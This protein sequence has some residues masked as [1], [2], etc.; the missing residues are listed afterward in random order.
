MCTTVIITVYYIVDPKQG[1]ASIRV[2]SSFRDNMARN[3]FSGIGVKSLI[4]WYTA[5]MHWT[6]MTNSFNISGPSVQNCSS[7]W[8]WQEK[9]CWL[10][11][12][13]FYTSNTCW[14]VRQTS[15]KTSTYNHKMGVKNH[16]RLS[17]K[18]SR[19]KAKRPQ[20]VSSFCQALFC[21]SK[22]VNRTLCGMNWV[23]L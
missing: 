12:P 6:A 16:L 2:C 1:C 8:L 19:E 13:W 18:C 11:H 15:T 4:T 20:L 7:I 9:E 21:C 3:Q 23:H 5:C 22:S 14:N 17:A 10:A